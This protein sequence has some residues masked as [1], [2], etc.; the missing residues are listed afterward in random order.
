MFV[1]NTQHVVV[2]FSDATMT[3]GLVHANPR[4]PLPPPLIKSLSSLQQE[5]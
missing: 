3:K 5:A 4:N 1:D 2:D